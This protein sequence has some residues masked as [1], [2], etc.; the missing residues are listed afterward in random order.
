MY[1]DTH[2]HDPSCG[3]VIVSAGGKDVD[4][5]WNTV[6]EL[7]GNHENIY[8]NSVRYLLERFENKLAS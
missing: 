1:V 4:S 3:A 7:E 8:G 2:C 5:F 6:W